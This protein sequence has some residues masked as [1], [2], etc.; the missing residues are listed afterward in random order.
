[1]FRTELTKNQNSMLGKYIFLLQKPS[2]SWTTKTANYYEDDSPKTADYPETPTR[3]SGG[4]KSSSDGVSLLSPEPPKEKT[5]LLSIG[6]HQSRR[7]RRQTLENMTNL[8]P[9]RTLNINSRSFKEYLEVGETIM[10][11]ESECKLCGS[12]GNLTLD[13]SEAE[14][15]TLADS[16]S[17]IAAPLMVLRCIGCYPTRFVFGTGWRAE[18]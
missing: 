2:K 14:P 4:S 12:T 6:A 10:N 5:F 11:F 3:A 9:V 13:V 17:E 7:R 15:L 8:R 18:S 16:A 1:M